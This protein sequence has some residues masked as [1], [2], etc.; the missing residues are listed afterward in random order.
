M[1]PIKCF[2]CGTSINDKLPLLRALK[3]EKFGENYNLKGGNLKLDTSKYDIQDIYNAI[4]ITN[5]CCKTRI[6]TA[7]N[8]Y[9]MRKL[10]YK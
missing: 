9:T 6:S 10:N 3:N 1:E 8:M 4:G 2:T 7:T 5:Y